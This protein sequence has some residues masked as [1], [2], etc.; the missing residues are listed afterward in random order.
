MEEHRGYGNG[1]KE[2]FANTIQ[3]DLHVVFM[4]DIR[5]FGRVQQVG[6]REC[7]YDSVYG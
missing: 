3:D 5:V 4:R 7:V 2:A 1:E 6:G